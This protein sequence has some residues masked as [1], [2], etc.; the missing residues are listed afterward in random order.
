MLV[1]RRQKDESVMMG[2]AV[3]ITIVDVRE[4][5]VRLGIT[6]PKWVPVHRREIYD[7]IQRERAQKAGE[8]NGAPVANSS[9][10]RTPFCCSGAYGSQNI[11]P[12]AYLHVSPTG[13][14]LSCGS[15]DSQGYCGFEQSD[16]PKKCPFGIE[17]LV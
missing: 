15:L 9:E 14:K 8:A 5:T 2:D 13:R 12:I 3:E 11:G 10:T 4:D 6:C 17:K 7:A 16:P 1:L